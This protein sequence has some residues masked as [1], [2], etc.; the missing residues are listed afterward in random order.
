MKLSEIVKLLNGKLDG[1]GEVEITGV[2][3]IESARPHEITFIANPVY[4]KFY[5]STRAGAIIVS[6]SFNK[7][8]SGDRK[9]PVIIADDPYLAF[10]ELLDRFAPEVELLKMGIDNSAVISKSAEISPDDISI[11]AHCYIGDECK[12]GRKVR[13]LPNC[14][15]MAGVVI[16]DDVLIHPN[17][18]IYNGCRIGNRVIIHSGTVVGSDGFGQ[19]KNKDGTYRKIPQRGIVVIE[20]DV[21]IG[22]GCTIDRATLGE[23]L[24]CRGVKLDN[25]IQIA[26]N[27]VIG[28][29]TVIAAQTG[30]AGS[31]KI[32]RNCIIGGKAGFVGHIEVCDDVIITAAT[33]VSKSI[34]KP[35]VY[36]GYRA[37]IQKK[38]LRQEASLRELEILKEKIKNLENKI[39]K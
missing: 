17:V 9:V 34:T 13:I 1:D 20:D 3:K 31:T 8:L 11:G 29:N 27:V 22:S 5:N 38:E 16:G 39:K 15:L 25:Q 19:A 18:T 7:H 32:G 23:T 12:I 26:H 4:E 21:E 6:R 24:I 28:E 14:V 33:N 10:V 2:G 35:G 36:S 37:Q 30:V